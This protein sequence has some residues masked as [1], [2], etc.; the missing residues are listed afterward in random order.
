MRLGGPRDSLKQ[1]WR[2]KSRSE[3]AEFPGN[4][5]GK[6]APSHRDASAA[7]LAFILIYANNM[8][9]IRRIL[10]YFY[11]DAR[12]SGGGIL[13]H[14]HPF[15][16]PGSG[17]EFPASFAELRRASRSFAEL[18]RASRSFA[19]LRQLIFNLSDPVV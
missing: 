2:Y 17:H 8:A 11:G 12:L 18:R 13:K 16:T 9:Y 7:S 14:E 19:E 15:I 3:N 6:T 1:P 4:S 10:S 5:A